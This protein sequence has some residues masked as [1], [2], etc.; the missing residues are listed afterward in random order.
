MRMVLRSTAAACRRLRPCVLSFSTIAEKR[1]VGLAARDTGRTTVA[2]KRA[3]A[4]A[5]MDSLGRTQ[6]KP[7]GGTQQPPML[8]NQSDGVSTKL[9]Q[10]RDLIQKEAAF[11]ALSL[12]RSCMRSV[13]TMRPGNENDIRDFE[14]R[15]EEQFKADSIPG[16]FSVAP[17]VDR[18]NELESRFE[19]YY[20]FAKENFEQDSTCL[21]GEPWREEDFQKY[22]NCMR[23]A[24]QTRTYILKDY[25]FVDPY[26]ERFDMNRLDQLE[27]RASVFVKNFYESKGWLHSSVDDEEYDDELDDDED[28]NDKDWK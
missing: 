10:E 24:E 22:F 28:L 19:Y 21:D 5:Y 16:V 9:Q 17:P 12:F 7:A 1:E 13:K 27:K 3:A 23:H 26:S 11:L 8:T 6:V 4:A 20:S 14:E 2:Q 18:E 15:E 25:Q